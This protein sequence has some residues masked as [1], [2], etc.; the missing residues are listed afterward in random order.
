MLERKPRFY[1]TK[2]IEIMKSIAPEALE[3][4][5]AT[6]GASVH[7]MPKELRTQIL[8]EQ[9]KCALPFLSPR[10]LQEDVTIAEFMFDGQT[11]RKAFYKVP[12]DE[13]PPLPR[14]L[15]RF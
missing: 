5:A 13:E 6:V 8:T 15:D 14:N 3:Q 7:E 9:I 10:D 4:L 11:K 1:E 2:M 12:P